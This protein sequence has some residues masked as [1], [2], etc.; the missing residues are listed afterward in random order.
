M[1]VHLSRILIIK[2]SQFFFFQR[3]TKHHTPGVIK[4]RMRLTAGMQQ[5]KL[6]TVAAEPSQLPGKCCNLKNCEMK[7]QNTRLKATLGTPTAV[8]RAQGLFP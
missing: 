8:R 1:L 3:A 5:S 2:V 4:T 6:N 7:R